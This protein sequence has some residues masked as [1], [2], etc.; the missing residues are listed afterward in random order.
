MEEDLKQEIDAAVKVLKEG[1]VILYPTDTVWGIGCDAT[2]KDAVA[3]VFEI[4]QRSDAKSLITLVADADMIGRY[5][6]VI[7]QMAIELIEVNDKPMTIIYPGA[8]GLA[9]NVV[10][11]DGSVGIRV[12]QSEFCRQ[13]CRRFG[14]AIVSTSANISGEEAPASFEDINAAI[15]DEVD[16]IV[17]PCYEEGATGISSQIIKVGLDGEVKVIRE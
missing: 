17:D 13:L 1:G 12:P 16:H 10:A 4:K 15:L 8:M 3:R 9:E 11:E 6:K 2:D 5:V 14:G 7:P